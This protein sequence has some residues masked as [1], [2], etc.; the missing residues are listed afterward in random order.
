M[1]CN[2]REIMQNIR[3]PDKY[4]YSKSLPKW[5]Y[6]L[7]FKAQIIKI[8][9][10]YKKGL[11]GVKVIVPL[12]MKCFLLKWFV[13]GKCFQTFYTLLFKKKK[14]T[15][16][17]WDIKTQIQ[18]QW[19]DSALIVKWNWSEFDDRWHQSDEIS[20]FSQLERL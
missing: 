1:F 19:P 18:N 9:M 2:W 16:S 4:K 12:L 3:Y 14:F 6:L 5:T 8:T 10:F 7:A 11:N 13:V 20:Y 15:F 17:I